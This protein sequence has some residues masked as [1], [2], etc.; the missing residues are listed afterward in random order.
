MGPLSSL[1]KAAGGR[2]R[3]SEGAFLNPHVGS[4]DIKLKTIRGGAATMLVQAGSLV[5][6]VGSSAAL[7]RMLTP[8][9]YGLVAM[10]TAVTG[11][12][13]LLNDVGLSAATVQ[14]E[15]VSEEQVS[16]LF[17]VNA[18]VGLGLMLVA[19]AA[20]P[21]VA[22]FYR[23]PRLLTITL[24]LGVGFLFGGLTVQHQALLTR[25]LRFG[26]LALIRIGSQIASIMVGLIMAHSGCGYWALVAMALVASLS[27]VCGVW[28]CCK[29]LP[30]KPVRY[31]G[32]RSMLAFGGN[33][34]GFS[35]VNY[36]ARN[37]DNILIGKV[38]GEGVLGLY[39]RAYNLL[40]LPITQIN[41]PIATVAIPG[42]SRLQGDPDGFRR[43]Y[44]RAVWCVAVLTVPLAAL[45]II[46]ADELVLVL[47]GSKW[48][49][50]AE[51]FRLLAVSALLQPVLNTCGWLYNAT[52]QTKRLFRWGIFSAGC[53]VCSFG[54]GLPYG[55]R[56]VAACYS[57]SV[58]LLAW[59]CLAYAARNTPV[60]VHQVCSA[61]FYPFLAASVSSAVAV[62]VKSLARE[63][64]S[65]LVVLLVVTAAMGTC[66]CTL[67]LARTGSRRDGAAVLAALFRGKQN[68]T[69]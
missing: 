49:E 62:W 1:S 18:T 19:A 10:V 44:L 63:R 39:A 61:V 56:G 12:I 43:F 69:S 47:L 25:Q 55:A 51:I 16:T 48:I 24:A 17:W 42:L 31:S 3:P 64:G 26:T 35:L 29:W 6:S 30:G 65:P 52:G 8:S 36:F 13:G 9:D 2:S 57:T 34:T 46:T 45:L 68:A 38:W 41:N 37:L 54:V 40:L 66:F 11:L 23:E 33:L 28:L 59:P 22:W 32:V 15:R 58:V 14:R 20:A 27:Q 5:L 7:A 60:K 50:A 67:L 4:A 21:A 53:T